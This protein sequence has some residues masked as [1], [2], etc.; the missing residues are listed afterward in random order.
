VSGYRL[1]VCAE[2]VFLDLPFVERVRRISDLGFEVEMWDWTAKDIDALA[3]TGATFSSMTGYISGTLADPDGADE[4]L[5][6]AEVSLD[7]AARLGC[8]R[9][10]VHGIAGCPWSPPGP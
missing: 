5:R 10:N 4:L 8:P 7:T 6:T 9:L 1:A 3:K 2:M